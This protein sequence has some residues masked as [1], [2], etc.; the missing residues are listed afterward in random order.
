MLPV[1]A[2]LNFTNEGVMADRPN[3][4]SVLKTS[5]SQDW[6]ESSSW[7][8]YN[9]IG[10]LLPMWGG[11]LLLYIFGHHDRWQQLIS[12]GEFALYSAALL[13]PAVYV[14]LK[15]VTPTS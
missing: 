8:L 15:D 1:L 14:V 10:G 4:I 5:E 9:L 3:L 11:L 6:W 2:C 7:L 12:R 13:A